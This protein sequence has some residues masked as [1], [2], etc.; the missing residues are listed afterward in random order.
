MR[1]L[2]VFL[3]LLFILLITVVASLVLPSGNLPITDSFA[4]RWVS[5]DELMDTKKPTQMTDI[6]SI[7]NSF[8]DSIPEQTSP[9]VIYITF[10]DSLEAANTRSTKL[11]SSI[12]V[13]RNDSA[14]INKTVHIEYPD[15]TFGALVPFFERLQTISRNQKPL[16][17]IHYGDSQIEGD[18][19]S[20]ILRQYFQKQFGGS[21]PGFICAYEEQGFAS[22]V[23][24]KH[25]GDWIRYAR[26]GLRDSSVWHSNFG[27][28]L[29][30]ARF[31]PLSEDVIPP[32]D[33]I[34]TASI[35][36]ESKEKR[37][38]PLRSVFRTVDIY[39]G[40]NRQDFFVE[41]YEGD[42]LLHLAGAPVGTGVQKISYRS[43]HPLSKCTLSFTGADSPDIYGISLDD[44]AGISFDNIPM[45]GSSGLEFSSVSSVNYTDI[46]HMLDVGLIVM[47]Y[48][49]NVVP[50]VRKSYSYYHT[51]FLKQIRYLQRVFPL[52]PILVIGLSDMAVK[53]GDEFVSSPNIELIRD[54]QKAAAFESGCA[55]WDLYEAMGGANSMYS[56]VNADPPLA[57]KDY[58]HFNYQGAQLVGNMLYRALIADFNENVSKSVAKSALSVT[59]K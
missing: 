28:M 26:Y 13:I 9:E 54:A 53:E 56:W 23:L 39:Y 31:S 17:I 35:R 58:T 34:R 42:S 3:F 32:P 22:P 20:G 24:Y 59:H 21:G 52:C 5:F 50:N 4:I 46:A 55:F 43:N 7:I 6:S 37:L 45:R 15:S 38:Y 36:I 18:R 12:L 41:I 29:S 33:D 11:S 40:G 44:T 49:V 47:Q 1:P 16:R 48:G 10:N 19:I 14:S 27:H 57:R 8:N 25:K 2:G 30:F 51:A